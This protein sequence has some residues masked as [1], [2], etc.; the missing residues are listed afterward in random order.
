MVGKC[1]IKIGEKQQ[2]M[3]NEMRTLPL[4]SS[5]PELQSLPDVLKRFS[6]EQVRLY[7]FPPPRRPIGKLA[8][9]FFFSL[10]PIGG[11]LFAFMWF[12]PRLIEAMDIQQRSVLLWPSEIV[13][14]IIVVLPIVWWI[15]KCV[16][17]QACSL[18]RECFGWIKDRIH[19]RRNP[20][21]SE[22]EYEW[23]IKDIGKKV[24]EM[25]P[26]KLHLSYTKE[27]SK[28]WVED[29]SAGVYKEAPKRWKFTVDLQTRGYP[30]PSSKNKP[31]QDKSKQAYRRTIHFKDWH[32]SINIFVRLF[33][34]KDYVATY[35]STVNVREPEK[36]REKAEHF[37]HRHLTYVSRETRTEMIDEDVIKQDYL[38]LKLDSGFTIRLHAA[39]VEFIYEGSEKA[40]ES[41]DATHGGLLHVLRDH[42]MSEMESIVKAREL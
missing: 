22:E 31:E 13:L 2:R 4:F 37:Y 33:I 20:P 6:Q 3:V 27:Y 18:G 36:I 14:D 28:E 42:K 5:M 30:L 24:Y 26:E 1:K 16:I 11:L 29:I 38:L 34:T 40:H 15:K 35:T 7:F 41:V 32:Y 39:T 9:K 8:V 19:L 17:P 10:A 12:H 23:W 21:P 25:A